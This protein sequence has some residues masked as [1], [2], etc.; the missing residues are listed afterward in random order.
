MSKFVALVPMRGGSKSI[1]DKNIKMIGG[2][3]LC[4]WALEAAC[5]SGVFDRIVVSTDSDK[6]SNV[7]RGLGLGIEVLKRPDE[8]ATDSATTESVML[9]MA[10]NVFFDVLVTIQVTSPFVSADDFIKSRDLFLVNNCDSLLTVVRT[11]RFFWNDDGTPLN[12]DPTCRPIRQDFKGVLMENG[13]FYFTRREVLE[14]SGCRLGGKVATYEMASESATEID[15]PEDWSEVER[16]LNRRLSLDFEALLTDLKLL[17]VDV[18]GTLTDAGM[19]Y[20]EGG[21]MLKKFNTRDAKGLELVRAVGVKVALMTSENSPVVLARAKKLGIEH[22]FTG[23]TDK[24]ALLMEFCASLGALLK[25]TAY[26]G[27][28]INDL[29]AMRIS[30]FRACPVDAMP[31][32]KSAAQYVS[33]LCGGYGAVRDICDMIVEAKK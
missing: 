17:V 23:V 6:I 2:K 30:G 11:R 14:R 19:Y 12:Y 25:Q 26:I 9:H 18:D 29:E 32:I 1:P 20:S 33:P 8:L 27:D 15:E 21:E 7:V 3:P 31:A 13:A 24:G 4:A 10:A 16:L 5:A 28:D 22:C